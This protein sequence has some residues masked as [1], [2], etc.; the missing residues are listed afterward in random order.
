MVKMKSFKAYFKKE[1]LEAVRTNRYLIIFIGTVFWALVNP[2]TL[3]L[4]PLLLKN[5]LPAN[6]AGILS[7]FDRDYAFQ[8]FLNDLFQ[9]STIFIVFS[10]MGLIAGEVRTKKLI[11][12]YSRGVNPSGMVL[13]KYM[14]YMVTISFFMIISFLTNYLYV[15]SL[16]TGGILSIVIALKSLLLYLLYYSLLL[17]IL[18][19]FSSLFKRSLITGITTLILA[20]TLSIFNQ[21]ETIRAYFPNYLLLKA[22]DISNVFDSSLIPTIIISSGIIILLIYLSTARMKKIDIA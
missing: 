8:S 7:T 5:Y 21:F 2:L 10:L 19:Y 22:A 17:S 9:V 14:H 20:Y 1:T 15:N 16:F 18:L 11:F 6:L 13:A 12:P 3:K 4:L